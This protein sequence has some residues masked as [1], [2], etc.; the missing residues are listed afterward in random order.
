MSKNSIII[1]IRAEIEDPNTGVPADF[2]TVSDYF[3]NQKAGTVTVNIGSYF[4]KK[5]HDM[6]KQSLGNQSVTLYG[7]PPRS[8][9]TLNWIYQNTVAPVDG[10]HDIY[11]N[12]LPP[13]LFTGAELLSE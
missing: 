1:G 6:G 5:H 11:G 12:L 7:L 2:H 8:Q 4:S 13:N 10:K 9:D 3:V